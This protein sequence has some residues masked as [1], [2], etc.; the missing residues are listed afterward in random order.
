MTDT[1]RTGP[2]RPAGVVVA[3]VLMLAA[4][5]VLGLVVRAVVDGWDVVDVL[6]RLVVPALVAAGIAIYAG[7]PT[8]RTWLFLGLAVVPVTVPIGVGVGFVFDAPWIWA[9]LAVVLGALALLLAMRGGQGPQSDS[10][11]AR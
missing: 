10:A 9:F 1:D 3:S 11:M 4:S 5:L 8:A 2:A 7:R 6:A